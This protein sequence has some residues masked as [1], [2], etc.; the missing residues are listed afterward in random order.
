MDYGSSLLRENSSTVM[1]CKFA[2]LQVGHMGKTSS[3]SLTSQNKHPKIQEHWELVRNG[4]KVISHP[5]LSTR[6]FLV[7]TAIQTLIMYAAFCVTALKM[8]L[9]NIKLLS[10]SWHSLFSNM[11]SYTHVVW[12]YNPF[13]LVSSCRT[14]LASWLLFLSFSV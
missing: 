8:K 7:L 9:Q 2:S 13:S 4:Y 3:C 1:P 10:F 6:E 12:S 5:P 14:K 11:V